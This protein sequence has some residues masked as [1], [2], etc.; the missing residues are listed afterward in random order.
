MPT[1]KDRPASWNDDVLWL[2]ERVA[3]LT[4]SQGRG[5]GSADIPLGTAVSPVS[6]YVRLTPSGLGSTSVVTIQM[7]TTTT[8]QWRLLSVQWHRAAG[9]ATTWAPRI[10]Q[11]AAFVDDGPDDRLEVA[12]QAFTDPIRKVYCQPIPMTADGTSRLYFKPGL[13]AGSDNDLDLQFWF[14]Q[15]Y[16][17]E[18]ST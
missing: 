14:I 6:H 5:T 16:E 12:A 17:T 2:L 7:P 8:S 9:S 3:G 18:E 11:T 15:D 1:S 4:A 13:D 10:G